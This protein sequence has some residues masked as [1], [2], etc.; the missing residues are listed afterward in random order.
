MSK[1]ASSIKKNIT[2]DSH[3]SRRDRKAVAALHTK[4]FP[5]IKHHITSRIGSATDAE[6][7]AQDVFVEFYKG[8]GCFR[9]NEDPERYLF[10]IARNLIRGYYRNRARSVRTTPIEETGSPI[11]FHD[12][13]Q[14]SD[15]VNL[16]EKK[17]L[18]KVIEQAVTKLPPKA[19]QAFELRFVKGL[20]S[21]EAAQNSGCT[22]STFR[23]R[24]CYAIRAIQKVLR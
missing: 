23:E 2:L 20:N 3:A 22:E 13:Q 7:L 4:Y 1:D 8:N 14:Y 11:T 9:E 19:R 15:P 17:E 6:D 12:M 10:G 24:L 5:R 21:K 18:I 16:N